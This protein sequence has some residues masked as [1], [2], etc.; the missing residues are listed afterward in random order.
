MALCRFGDDSDLYV[1][2]SVYGG[3][4]CCHCRLMERPADLKADNERE[5]IAHLEMHMARSH[6]F[7]QDVFEQLA[8][9]ELQ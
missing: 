8:N 9:P 3:I 7:P 1:Y 5:M 6:K 2:Y 4:I